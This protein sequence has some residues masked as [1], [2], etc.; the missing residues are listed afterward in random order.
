MFA[1]G[2]TTTGTTALIAVLAGLVGVILGGWMA[3]SRERWRWRA[4]NRRDA[5][6]EM[7]RAVNDV[8]EAFDG[9]RSAHDEGRPGDELGSRATAALEAGRRLDE[10]RAAVQ[11]L[12]S[13]TMRT[14]VS[15][16]EMATFAIEAR[17]SA[18][19]QLVDMWEPG[20]DDSWWNQ[21]IDWSGDVEGIALAELRPDR[22]RGWLG[23]RTARWNRWR[24][25]RRADRNREPKEVPEQEGDE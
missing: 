15:G 2:D 24:N 21:A 3:R 4:D 1:V 14:Y 6:L 20:N 17:F 12:G 23:T 25:R 13:R 9:L 19:S 10:A 5:Y 7:L 18:V 11:I 16:S 22:L 8:N